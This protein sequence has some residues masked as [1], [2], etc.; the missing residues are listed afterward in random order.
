MNNFFFKTIN[1][2]IRIWR[3]LLYLPQ[4]QQAYKE[5]TNK[6]VNPAI[7]ASLSKS[8]KSSD[9]RQRRIIGLLEQLGVFPNLSMLGI[10]FRLIA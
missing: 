2:R 3:T 1:K 7:K 6:G 10:F 5:V 8:L 9:S 4:N